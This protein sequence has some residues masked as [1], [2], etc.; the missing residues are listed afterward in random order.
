MQF[1]YD[2]R[3]DLGLFLDDEYVTKR[4]RALQMGYEAV[5]E[6]ANAHAGPA[7]L[8]T[9]EE[10]PFTPA[11]TRSCISLTDSQTE[12][13]TRMKTEGIRI[14]NRYIPEKDRSFTII[15]YPVPSIGADFHAIFE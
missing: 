3:E 6:E 13:M 12:K 9:F 8:E 11:K 5:K 14:T 15:A 7:V 4:L 10:E 2:H 1:D